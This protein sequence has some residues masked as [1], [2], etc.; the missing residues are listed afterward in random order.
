M[1][2]PQRTCDG[3]EQRRAIAVGDGNPAFNMQRRK[4]TAF[5]RVVLRLDGVVG[6]GQRR[7]ARERESE[8]PRLTDL[9]RAARDLPP[10]EGCHE[11][12]FGRGL[13]HATALSGIQASKVRAA[14]S[15]SRT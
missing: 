12:L 2:N 13:F 7:Q 5:W 15:I 9:N 4:G 14:G 10:S 3:G 1:T 8:A 11:V 6:Y